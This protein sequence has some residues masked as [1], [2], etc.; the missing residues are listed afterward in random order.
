[1]A[2]TE[3]KSVQAEM[4][5][6][7]DEW[8]SAA[9]VHDGDWYRDNL[10]EEFFYINAGGGEVD[11]E[12]IVAIADKSQRSEYAMRSVSARRYGDVI[13]AHG[14]YFGKGDFPPGGGISEEMRAAYSR[15]SEI[16]FSGTWV[17]QGGRLKCLH[18]QSTPI[19]A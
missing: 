13:L 3:Q 6:L 15:G 4:E 19:G 12:G 11:V 9:Q 10:A 2:T 5:R 1:M 18:L 7:Y 14:R 16:A 17:E 8:M